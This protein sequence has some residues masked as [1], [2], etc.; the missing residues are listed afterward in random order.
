MSVPAMSVMVPVVVGPMAFNWLFVPTNGLLVVS[1]IIL[2][3]II[4]LII[5]FVVIFAILVKIL[6]LSF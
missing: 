2:V 1:V 6:I 4:I 3:I 5:I